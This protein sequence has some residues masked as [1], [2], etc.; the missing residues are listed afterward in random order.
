[1]N[2]LTNRHHSAFKGQI[3]SLFNLQK[4]DHFLDLTLGDGGHTQEALEAGAQVISFDVDLESINR[5]IT[6]IGHQ[7]QPI[8]VNPRQ[9]DLS[10]PQNANW[11]IINANMTSIKQIA[12]NLAFPKF[13]GILADLGPSQYQILSSGRGFSFHHDQP[14]DMRLDKNLGVTAKD[15]VNALGPKELTNLFRLVDESDAL[16]I[17]KAII[18]EREHSP[19][20]TTNQLVGIVSKIKRGRHKIHPATKV[21]LALRMA[22]NLEREVI[23]TT[24]PQLPSLLDKNGT[25]GVI[26]FHSGEDRLVKQF[27]KTQESKKTLRVINP[28]P[29][30]PSKDELKTTKRTRSA[31]L[32]LFKKY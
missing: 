17:A 2:K 7:Y 32:R 27:G 28:K 14:L 16:T 13:K 12:K 22:T 9:K 26:S 4:G 25:L 5:A 20:E 18:K 1:M 30:T 19:I 3:S 31:K 10:L 11:V 23:T 24:L 21:F 15:L 8:L 6:F 29:L